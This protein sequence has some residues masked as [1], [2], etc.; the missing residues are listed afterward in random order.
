MENVGGN[1]RR[2]LRAHREREKERGTSVV[3]KI[4]TK[5][6]GGRVFNEFL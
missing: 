5:I 1:A 4:I 3:E 6:T 2:K